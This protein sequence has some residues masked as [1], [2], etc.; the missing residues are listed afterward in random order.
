[1]LEGVRMAVRGQV[2]V[3]KSTID[4]LP[5]A[6]TAMLITTYQS[7]KPT[8]VLSLRSVFGNM[9]Q[10]ILQTVANLGFVSRTR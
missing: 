5:L 1:M 9:R 7:A 2:H 3:S 6:N 10:A 4:G 8:A